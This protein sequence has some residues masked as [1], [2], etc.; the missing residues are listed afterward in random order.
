[1]KFD[2]VVLAGQGSFFVGGRRVKALDKHEPANSDEPSVHRNG[3]SFW[4]DQMYVQYQIPINVQNL[5]MVLVHGGGGTGRV[6][7]TTPDGREGYQTI[8][9]RR[10]FPVYIVDLPRGGR[11]GFPSFNGEFGRLDERQVVVQNITKR[12]SHERAWSR[13]RLGPRYPEK[14]AVQAFPMDAIDQF[15]QHLRPIVTDDAEVN[16]NA[17]LAL[18]EKIG[19][20]VLITHSNSG[21]PG[22]LAGARSEKVKAIVSY[23]PGFVFPQGEVP[24]PIPMSKGFRPSDTPVS[25]E[26]FVQLAKVPLQVVFGDNIPTGVVEDLP[27]DERRAQVKACD[28]FV[29]ALK[30]YDGKG[31]VLHLP[32]VGIHGNSHFMFA[33]INNLQ[34]ADQLSNFLSQQGLESLPSAASQ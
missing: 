14:F 27:A 9:L 7:E 5:P 16:C 31:S 28:L 32:Q 24:Q 11:S 23:E 15:M 1:M 20:A 30:K 21:V 19:P 2:P 10:G 4:V 18:L 29:K 17:L 12:T 26:E 3:Q 22:W 13:W 33:D 34:V 6:W 8:F 25:Q